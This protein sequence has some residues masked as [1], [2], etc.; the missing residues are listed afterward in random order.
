MSATS[1]GAQ[2]LA[3]ITK[4]SKSIRPAAN[5]IPLRNF[6]PRS[7]LLLFSSRD[8]YVARLGGATYD[9]HSATCATSLVDL[10]P[11]APRSSKIAQFDATVGF[12]FFFFVSLF[13]LL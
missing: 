4:A 12:F 6:I 3:K 8:S 2:C 5:P 9:F 13:Q 7:K 11:K 10:K 1:S